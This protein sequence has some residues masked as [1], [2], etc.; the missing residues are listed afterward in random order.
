MGANGGKVGDRPGGNNVMGEGERRQ[1]GLNEGCGG[2]A[3]YGAEA[4][5]EGCGE[6]LVCQG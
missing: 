5:G 6:G 4:R 1:L 2:V 3:E